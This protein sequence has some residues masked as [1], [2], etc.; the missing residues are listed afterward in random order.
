MIQALSIE[1]LQNL[2]LVAAA[3]GNWQSICLADRR[4]KGMGYPAI[5]IASFPG[6]VDANG[7]S[8]L[9]LASMH[10]QKNVVLELLELP[11]PPDARKDLSPA[12]LWCSKVQCRH[13]P[14]FP[15]PAAEKLQAEKRHAR[16]LAL[17]SDDLP[18][19]MSNVGNHELWKDWLRNMKDTRLSG[20]TA[21]SV[22][23]EIFQKLFQKGTLAV[24]GDD[25]RSGLN[26]CRVLELCAH[27]LQ[28]YASLSSHYTFVTLFQVLRVSLHQSPFG[29]NRARA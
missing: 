11:L 2:V 4:F 19:L 26:L 5:H 12:S 14:L 9:H 15:N 24:F 6:A 17:V 25:Q 23:L 10:G 18:K 13:R 21:V 29:R 3:C 22:V 1:E 8:A 16:A 20:A 7:L 28:Q 27:L